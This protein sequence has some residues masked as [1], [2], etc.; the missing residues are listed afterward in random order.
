MKK[1]L[2][3]F[4]ALL[5]VVISAEA[6]QPIH[7]LFPVKNADGTTIMLY[8]QGDRHFSFYSTPDN[9]VVVRNG[10]G[11]LCYGMMENGE[12]LASAVLA[13]D[14]ENRTDDEKAFVASNNLTVRDASFIRFANGKRIANEPQ[15]VGGSST[16]DG[17]GKYGT[18]ATGAVPTVGDIKIPVI[19]VQ[20][21]D[22]KFQESTTIEKLTRFFNEE[23]Y[24]ED[25]NLE[26]GSVKDYFVSQSRGLFNPTFDVVALVTLNH[27]YAYYGQH[28]GTSSDRRAFDMVKDAVAAAKEQGVDFE[29]YVSDKTDNVPNVT[30]YYAGPGEATGGDDNTIW[31]HEMDLFNYTYYST[32]G[33][34]SSVKF[35]S[36]YVGNEIYG[37]ESSTT[38]MGMGVFCHEFSHAM[39]LPD[40]Y[41]PTYSYTDDSPFGNWSVMD[42]GPYVNDAYAPVG[43]TAYE[44]SF[45]G[46]L[47]IPELNDSANVTL[48]DPNNNEAQ[49]AV[50]LRNPDNANEYFIFENRQPGN[51]YNSSDGSGVLVTRIS[52]NSSAWSR[53]TVNTSQDYKRAM[54]VTASGRAISSRSTQSSDLFGNGVNNKLTHALYSGSTLEGYELYKILKQPDGTIK[55]NFKNKSLP[56][57]SVVNDDL[58]E[59]VTDVSTLAAKDTVIIVCEDEGMA[60]GAEQQTSGRSAINV[61]VADGKAYG[62]D[63][64]QKLTLLTT[65]TGNFG[66]WLAEKNTYLGASNSGLK[67]VANADESCIANITITDGNASITFMGKASRKN[68]GYSVDDVQFSS[69]TTASGNIQIYRKVAEFTGIMGIEADAKSNVASQRV[70]NLNG[71]FVGTSLNGL[72]KGIYVHQGKKVVVK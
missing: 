53:N 4:F 10:E 54:I 5:V 26:H 1:T 38:L 8:K 17:L 50:L 44:R 23:G 11:M 31:P 14:L 64:V 49:M 39:G 70:Y 16:S 19:M 56:F 36:Y 65:N 60:L 2:L 21:T 59:R 51:W 68:L 63:N 48:S 67:T 33:N 46:W 28:Y 55:F 9:Y 24:H 61:N 13:H 7:K 42:T 71:Q 37:T 20:F 30:I 3:V 41:D 6:I 12:L 47:E 66:F 35:G 32:L 34:T 72:P 18:S 45:M 58:Y 62:N 29:Q 52:Y 27:G 15:K 40:F 69:Y 22:T 57:E 25:N 43:Y